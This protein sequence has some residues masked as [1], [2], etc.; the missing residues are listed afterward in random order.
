MSPRTKEITLTVNGTVYRT[1][2]A[3][4]SRLLDYL[5]D[6]LGL[7]GA[8]EGC[9]SG[10]CGACTVLVDSAPICSCLM[11]L[12]SAAGREVT[13]IEGLGDEAGGLDPLQEAFVSVGAVQCGFCTPGLVLSARAFLD[14]GGEPTD[15]AIRHAIAGNLCRCTGYTKVVTAIRHAANTTPGKEQ[16]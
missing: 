11:I 7:T 1:S 16:P 6:E 8:K 3:P 5:R 4:T 9:G 13:T 14:R 15:E 2:A 12:G 10:E